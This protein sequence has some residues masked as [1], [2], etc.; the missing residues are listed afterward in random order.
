MRISDWS[1]DVCSSDLT[2]GVAF[3]SAA[4]YHARSLAACPGDDRRVPASHRSA[5]GAGGESVFPG[6]AQHVPVA[7][8]VAAQQGGVM[9][10]FNPDTLTLREMAGLLRRGVLTRAS[11]L[12]FYLQRHRT[13]PDERRGGKRCGS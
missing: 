10:L 12:E 4:E 11:L 8:Q 7:Q 3:L 13:R 2:P 5:P 1:S 9:S 6:G